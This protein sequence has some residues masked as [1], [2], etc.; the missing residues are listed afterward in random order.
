MTKE[1]QVKLIE[2]I[3]A[4]LAYD[5]YKSESK[6]LSAFTEQAQADHARLKHLDGKQER[7]RVG[8]FW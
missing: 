6:L 8:N 2:E 4:L 3:I 5:G 1:T 7:E